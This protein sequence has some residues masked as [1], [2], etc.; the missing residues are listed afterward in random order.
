MRRIRTPALIIIFLICLY[1][2]HSAAH[3]L[4]NARQT[5]NEIRE[6]E[7]IIGI[8]DQSIKNSETEIAKLERDVENLNRRIAG[9]EEDLA[10]AEKRH[11]EDINLIGVRLRSLY[12]TG[13][14][15]YLQ[16]FLEA[17]SFGDLIIRFVYLKRILESD[18]RIIASIIE[19][20]EYI[21][22][23]KDDI[24][25]E[26]WAVQAKQSLIEEEIAGLL[27]QRQEK[28]EL[29]VSTIT[30]HAQ[31]RPV[32]GVVLDNHPQARPQSGLS[33]AAKV[34]EF[35]VEAR[36][37]RYLA[38]FSIF[39]E[40]VGPIRSARTHSTLLA[41][42]ND[43]HFIYASATA[44]VRTNIVIWGLNHTNALF[45][46]TPSIYRSRDRVAPH[47]LYVNL[48]TLNLENPSDSLDIRPKDLDRKGEPAPLVSLQYNN[49]TRIEYR[50]DS[51][52]QAYRRYL[53][54]APHRD[55]AGNDILA[56]NLIV[57]YTSHPLDHRNRPTPTVTGSGYMDYYA[58]GQRFRG[59]WEKPDMN[60]PTRF[61]HESGERMEMIAGQ[62]WVQIVRNR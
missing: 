48:S 11:A 43:V 51:S 31:W 24:K 19:E 41:K 60:T 58:Q 36:N 10:A 14:I 45:A 18:A 8:L 17:D 1:G 40:K 52:L 30:K 42:E 50:Y 4:Q 32:Y 9:V 23:L 61:Y 44:D 56:W 6:L 29:L 15:P 20:Y 38:L 35:E 39:P 25:E 22:R 59:K 62:T 49:Y 33:Q 26:R 5:Q 37:T 7:E 54:G 12:T 21:S 53:N 57:Q 16:A 27:E 3:E 47:N 55:A 13:S 34:Y 2:A 28:E 46:G